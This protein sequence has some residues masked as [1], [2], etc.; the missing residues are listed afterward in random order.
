MEEAGQAPYTSFLK[1]ALHNT[2]LHKK[3]QTFCLRA[4]HAHHK[5]SVQRS[6]TSHQVSMQTALNQAKFQ[7]Q[8]TQQSKQDPSQLHPPSLLPQYPQHIQ[9]KMYLQQSRAAA[10]AVPANSKALLV[11]AANQTVT[12]PA[13]EQ[14]FTP[15]ELRNCGAQPLVITART[16]SCVTQVFPSAGCKERPFPANE[17][18]QTHPPFP[19]EDIGLPSRPQFNHS[20]HPPGEIFL[21]PIL[22]IIK[23]NKNK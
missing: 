8:A 11:R 3:P 6:P 2:T 19:S 1:N 9:K 13:Q 16:G 23:I 4:G 10:K 21:R 5:D 18:P 7:I 22:N 15:P 14:L 17:H 12:L 20:T